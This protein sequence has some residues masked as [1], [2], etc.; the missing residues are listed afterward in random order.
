MVDGKA[1]YYVALRLLTDRLAVLGSWTKCTIST[2]VTTEHGFS[3]NLG[4]SQS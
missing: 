3:N 1:N 2:G 4:S